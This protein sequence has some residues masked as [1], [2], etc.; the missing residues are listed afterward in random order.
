M[1]R[2]QNSEALALTPARRD[3]L[4]ILEAGYAAIDTERVIDRTVD[5]RSDA[6]V[7]LGRTFD[8]RSYENIYV[9]GFG[10]G[11]CAA[12]GALYRKL[13]GRLKKAVVIDRSFHETCPVEVEAYQGTHPLPSAANVEAT[14]VIVG[15]A[16]Q[17]TERDLVIVVVAGGGSAL[18]CS[19]NEECDQSGLLFQKA[20]SWG[21]TI[22]ELNLI[23]R[24][25]SSLKGGGLAKALHPATVVSLIFSDI[26]GGNP[27]DVASGPTYFD[28]STVDDA[29]AVL[30]KYG[31]ADAFS[32][33]ETPKDR[34]Y[35]ENVTNIVLV[36]NEDALESMAQ[37]ARAAGYE[38][39]VLEE[40]LYDYPA[41]T[42][43]RLFERSLPGRVVLAGGEVRLKVPD[44]HGSGGR[45]QYLA[46]E[47][48][49]RIGEHVLLAAASD[50]RD[51]CDAAGA[52]ADRITKEHVASLNIDLEDA[53][54]RLDTYPLFNASGD[55]IMTG[56]TDANVSDWYILLS[57]RV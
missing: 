7:V 32:L 49:E 20:S 26:V 50:G 11:S 33:L 4:S 28:G 9:M 44:D 15:I 3:A 18:L 48:L 29:R 5:V 35:F 31:A 25:I 14:Q 40:P 51:N 45:C 47:A 21:A 53:K 16:N 46:L 23:R 22:Q 24:H 52:I 12:V 55:A 57:P 27:Q 42:L 8:T 17:A 1:G 39:H 34:A 36:S 38:A 13:E 19:S 6:I 43:D 10:K 30:E 56:Q 2:V 37:A 54:R 41:A